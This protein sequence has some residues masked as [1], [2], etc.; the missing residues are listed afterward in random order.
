[1]EAFLDQ[2]QGRWLS[3]FEADGRARKDQPFRYRALDVLAFRV[4]GR[5]FGFVCIGAVEL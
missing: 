1:M 5:E 4:H 3:G 2:C